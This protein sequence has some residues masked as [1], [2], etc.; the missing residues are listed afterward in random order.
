MALPH[1]DPADPIRQVSAR[2][3]MT[4]L[5]TL[6]LMTVAFWA[7]L[8]WMIERWTLADSYYSHGPLVPLVALY[9]VWRDRRRLLA[10][11]AEPSTLGLLILLAGLL[12]LILSGLF[13]V[14]FTAAFGMLLTIWGLC[15][16]LFG[17]RALRRLAFPVLMLVFMI[18][19]PLSVIADVSLRMKL[20]ATRA[21][22]ALLGAFG[23]DS[24]NDGSKIYLENGATVTVGNACSGLRS[25]I[26]LIFL[27]VLFAT[28]CRLRFW[29]RI[30]LFASSV[31][32]AILANIVRVFLL[33][34]VAN[35]WGERAVHGFV[36]DASGYLIYLV[37]F[38]L[39][40][41]TSWLLGLGEDPS[42]GASQGGEP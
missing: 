13:T 41:A 15:G 39:L 21:A 28:L 1:L 31:P 2:A 14:Y 5:L 18:P 32:I 3:W 30:A 29:K 7:P 16:F 10:L 24:V 8:T 40:Y 34:L 9:F 4:G 17:R 35:Q 38:L 36:H 19:L 42:G 27:G 33:C 11:R 37:A 6:V 23:I 26:A 22:L 25:L 12:V 20:F